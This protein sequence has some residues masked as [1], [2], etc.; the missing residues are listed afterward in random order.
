MSALA[1]F[2]RDISRFIE[3]EQPPRVFFVPGL[4][5]FSH[6]RDNFRRALRSFSR[7]RQVVDADAT[8][9]LESI[10]ERLHSS[11][12]AVDHRTELA[13]RMNRPSLLATALG[14]LAELEQLE[15][16]VPQLLLELRRR[17]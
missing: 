6:D 2:R 5:T 10:L 14:A 12:Y 3:S 4:W 17:L 9:P 8:G 16:E 7:E 1:R 13:I 15:G 11:W